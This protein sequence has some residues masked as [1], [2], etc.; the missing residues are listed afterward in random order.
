VPGTGDLD[1]VSEP[2]IPPIPVGDWPKAMHEALAAMLPENP[3]HPRLK[4]E[5]RPKALNALGTLAQ[6]PELAKAFNSFNGH[7][8]YNT[9][10]S[11]RQ[12]EL[13]VLRVAHLRASAYEWAQHLVLAADLGI[14]DGEVARVIE[15]PDAEGWSTVEA[16]LVRATDELLADACITDATWADLATELDTHQLMDVVFTVGAYDLLAMAFRS[17]AIELDDD[18]A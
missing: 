15:G 18:L 14:D 11:P 4:T 8:I 17:F 7:I 10:L 9:S 5:G 13:L 3:R 12:R 16:A 1:L 2:R 6:H